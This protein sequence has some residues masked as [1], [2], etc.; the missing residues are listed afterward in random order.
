MM[1]NI[2]QGLLAILTLFITS[3]SDNSYLNVIPRESTALMALDLKKVADNPTISGQGEVL[4]ALFQVD[5]LDDCGLDFSQ[6]VYLFE[7]PDG[8]LGVCV[9]VAD[10]DD[11]EHWLTSLSQHGICQPLTKFHGFHFSI[12]KSQWVVGFSDAAMLVMGPSVASAQPALRQSI[13]KYLSADE[14]DGIK[15]SPMFERLDSISAPISLVAEAQAL[16][17]QLVAPFTLGA[18]KGTDP[19]QILLS[20]D[21][22]VKDGCLNIHGETFSFLPKVDR[23]LKQAQEV[24]RPIK[25][26]YVHSMPADATVGLFLNVDGKK[27]LPLMQA[28]QGIQAL[29]AGINTAIDMDNIIR[30]VD[31]DMSI[32]MPHFSTGSSQLMMAAKLAHA[33]W[34]SDVGY[35]KQSCPAGGKIADWGKNAYFYSDGKTTYYFGVSDDLQYFSGSDALS[36]LYAIKRSD[37]PISVALQQKIKGQKMVLLVNLSNLD[38]GQELMTAL[39]S[40]LKPI[41]GDFQQ[42]VYTLK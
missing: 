19:T 5:N 20:A 8:N 33:H 38:K 6:K 40:L 25:G 4:K 34:L 29:L 39:S 17:Q 14:E 27:F 36:A 41:F 18:P 35:W 21:I 26:Q 31:G 23:A 12:L 10:A 11:L 13:F 42:M 30:S 24:F 1:K 15:D 2:L 22:E 16:P 3:C 28:N 37:H 9:K 7:A 32:I